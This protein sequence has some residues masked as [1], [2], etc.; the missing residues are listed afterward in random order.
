MIYCLLGILG[1]VT[2]GAASL[3]VITYL[4]MRSLQLQLAENT[5]IPETI[6]Q[7]PTT[8]QELLEQL[9]H[10]NS[11]Y[12]EQ[13]TEVESRLA[14]LSGSGNSSFLPNASSQVMVIQ[15]Q[16]QELNLMQTV[17]RNATL[18]SIKTAE[19]ALGSFNSSIN[20]L[21]Q[22][23]S[24]PLSIYQNCTQEQDSCMHSV[25]ANITLYRSSCVTGLLS[26]NS[27]VS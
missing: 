7:L 18:D 17:L 11:S 24:S 4:E 13:L 25:D 14:T 19:I 10:V 16:L 15:T 9:Q 22:R 3:A 2:A 5:Q 8:V 21:N 26:V 23:V 1:L 12:Y 27:S 6:E 20:A